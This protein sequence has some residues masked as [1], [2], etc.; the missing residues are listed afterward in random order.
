MICRETSLQHPGTDLAAFLLSHPYNSRIAV[1]EGQV[2]SG[3]EPLSHTADADVYRYRLSCNLASLLSPAFLDREILSEGTEFIAL[4][5]GLDFSKSEAAGIS[6]RTLHL[7]VD[8]T[9]YEYLGLVGA[10]SKHNPGDGLQAGLV[11]LP[12]QA[13]P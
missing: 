1:A 6:D 7:I 10:R 8:S 3:I 4:C 13:D 2:S 12:Q 5:T 9:V 11:L